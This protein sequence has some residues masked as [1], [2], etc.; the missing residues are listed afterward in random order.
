M[1]RF[2]PAEVIATAALLAG[3]TGC[4]ST[5]LDRNKAV[6]LANARAYNEHDIAGLR[7]T[8]APDLVRRCQATPDITVRSADDFIAFATREWK[9]FPDGRLEVERLVAEGDRVGLFGHFVG[10]QRGPMGPFPASDRRMDIDFG[11]VFRIEDGRIA[12]IWV[13]WDNLTALAQLGHW[14]PESESAGAPEAIAPGSSG[15]QTP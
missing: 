15:R 11:G 4:A 9:T 5:S 13:T 3:V 8:M 12:E 1:N 14:S 7:D 2:S 6:V 10:T